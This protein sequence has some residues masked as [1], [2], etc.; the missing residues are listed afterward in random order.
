LSSETVALDTELRKYI[1]TQNVRTF[2]QPLAKIQVRIKI[3]K[4]VIKNTIVLS[5]TDLRKYIPT[6]AVAATCQNSNWN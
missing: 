6:H 1:P 2:V 3:K 4:K 5:D